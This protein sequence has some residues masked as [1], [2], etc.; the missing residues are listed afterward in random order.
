M[1]SRIPRTIQQT[2]P[3]GVQF[4]SVAPGAAKS[5]TYAGE[6]NGWESYAAE[7]AIEDSN[8][9]TGADFIVDNGTI[10]GQAQAFTV[11]AVQKYL[12]SVKLRL[13]KTGSPTGSLV[14]KLHALTGAYGS[15][16]IPTGAALATS[17]NLDTATLTG[18]YVVYEIA[19]VTQYLMAAG[20]QYAIVVEH[21]NGAVGDYVQIEGDSTGTHGGNRSENS[22]GWTVPS[23][24]D[25]LWFQ[26]WASQTGGL[27]APEHN[28]P[29]VV[30]RIWLS[31]GGQSAWSIKLVNEAG[32]EIGTL[33]SGTNEASYMLALA[34]RFLLLPGESLAVST[35]GM[36]SAGVL[37]VTVVEPG[38]WQS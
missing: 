10:S 33:A 15:A 28:K 20:G 13:K 14:V 32:T 38:A 31:M 2:V 1:S 29:L 3:A 34:S 16:A 18:S 19:F 21:A 37:R 22:G 8:A 9:E 26:C 12:T 6:Y 25:D 24:D 17:A 27:V 30:E 7:K 4:A 11:G 5:T 23:A 35:T 36:T